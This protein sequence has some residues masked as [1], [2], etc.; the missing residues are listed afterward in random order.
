MKNKYLIKLTFF[1]ILSMNSFATQAAPFSFGLWGDMP[2]AKA[3]DGTKLP[4]VLKSINAAKIDFSI[5][6]SM[7]GE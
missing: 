3:G 4:A 7:I 2:Y 1:S 6:R 5:L